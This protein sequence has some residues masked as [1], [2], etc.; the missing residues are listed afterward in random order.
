MNLNELAVAVTKKEGQK[1]NL[2]IAQVKE[3]I[4]VLCGI[5]ANMGFWDSL[6]LLRKMRANGKL[7]QQND[8]HCS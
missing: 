7:Q 5:F 8:E 6:A 2:T 4:H 1:V 3:V